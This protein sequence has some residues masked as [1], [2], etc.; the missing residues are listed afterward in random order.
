MN[1]LDEN[2]QQIKTS[3]LY[4]LNED[5]KNQYRDDP[6]A[7]RVVINDGKSHTSGCREFIGDD[8]DKPSRVQKQRE[9]MKTWV[10]EQVYEREELKRNKKEQEM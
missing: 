7:P 3:N 2:L 10:Q 4:Q 1:S 8:L 9:Q 6:L 5:R